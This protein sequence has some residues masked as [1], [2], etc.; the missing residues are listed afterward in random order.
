MAP[1]TY[2]EFGLMSLKD[3]SLATGQPDRTAR[4]HARDHKELI[5][6]RGDERV[7][8]PVLSVLPFGSAVVPPSERGDTTVADKTLYLVES[9]RM[10]QFRRLLFIDKE[11]PSETDAKSRQTLGTAVYT[12]GHPWV[13]VGEVSQ[14]LRLA[15]EQPELLTVFRTASN[16]VEIETLQPERLC[17]ELKAAWTT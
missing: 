5:D 15:R 10:E 6:T 9:Y 14:V 2:S 7:S 1:T 8:V 11:A 17:E 4:D 3:A 12:G 16:R 13:A